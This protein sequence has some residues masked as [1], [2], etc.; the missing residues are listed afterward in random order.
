[1]RR[2]KN[3]NNS[4]YCTVNSWKPQISQ[5]LE[6][7]KTRLLIC[8]LLVN[9]LWLLTGN[10]L[11]IWLSKIEQNLRLFGWKACICLTK[12][13]PFTWLKSWNL[14]SRK[15]S[16]SLKFCE[17]VQMQLEVYA[18]GSWIFTN[19]FTPSK[20]TKLMVLNLKILFLSRTTKK[21]KELELHRQN[22]KWL[23]NQKHIMWSRF[24]IVN[25]LVLAMGLPYLT[26]QRKILLFQNLYSNLCRTKSLLHLRRKSSNNL[27]FQE[28]E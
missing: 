6:P 8:K 20:Q 9:A 10:K 14:S 17:T 27:M 2:I 26:I 25:F 1:M 13:T 24:L 12:I 7:F 3:L 28:T 11:T 23:K 18:P 5:S 16:S 21:Q 19:I 15:T 4:V 22:Q